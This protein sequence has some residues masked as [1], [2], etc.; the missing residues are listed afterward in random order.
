MHRSS[1]MRIFCHRR[2]C[3]NFHEAE[4]IKARSVSAR[5]LIT[6]HQSGRERYSW[7]TVRIAARDAAVQSIR[8]HVAKARVI[9]Q[10]PREKRAASP[11]EHATEK[12]STFSP[13]GIVTVTTIN[14]NEGEKNLKVSSHFPDQP[15]SKTMAQKWGWF[16]FCPKPV[17]N[18]ENLNYSVQSLLKQSIYYIFARLIRKLIKIADIYLTNY[19][20][21]SCVEELMKNLQN[22]IRMANSMVLQGNF[23]NLQRL[24]FLEI[25]IIRKIC[26]INLYCNIN[27]INHMYCDYNS[28]I[29]TSLN[30]RVCLYLFIIY[31]LRIQSTF[32][33]L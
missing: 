22:E 12:L 27:Y 17:R 9:C 25:W 26:K 16:R 28:I 19:R 3:Q 1:S 31:I 29:S 23:I 21:G 20:P 11:C 5:S 2:G 6:E 4:C 8:C 15:E 32:I 10:C 24:V 13:L 7:R 33:F 30:I 18:S 14:E